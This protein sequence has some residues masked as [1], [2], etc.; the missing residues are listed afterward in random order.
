VQIPW[1]DLR[2]DHNRS[3][4]RREALGVVKTVLGALSGRLD[5]H[6]TVGYRMDTKRALQIMKLEIDGIVKEI[7]KELNGK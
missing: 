1:D 5:R 7:D 6:I 3:E 4:A 2:D